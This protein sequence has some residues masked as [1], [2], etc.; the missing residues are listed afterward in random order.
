MMNYR[1]EDSPFLNL[2]VFFLLKKRNVIVC[3]LDF[4]KKI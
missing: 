2:P 1:Q 4:S 3:N